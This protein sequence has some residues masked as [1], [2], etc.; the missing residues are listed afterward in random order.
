MGAYIFLS[1]VVIGI[2]VFWVVHRKCRR[3]ENFRQCVCSS[4]RGQTCQD[5]D[6][7]WASY[8]AGI[9]ENNP[10]F[11]EHKWSK[12][13]PGDVNF[14]PSKGCAWSDPNQKGWFKWDFTD[15]GSNNLPCGSCMA[16]PVPRK[17]QNDGSVENYTFPENQPYSGVMGI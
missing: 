2:L 13:S 11:G 6:Q 15:F 16:C 1:V 14:P 17:N 7:V 3:K 5:I 12:T 10:N 8:E 9:T 4:T